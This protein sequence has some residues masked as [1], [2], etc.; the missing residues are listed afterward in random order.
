MLGTF[1]FELWFKSYCLF[2]EWSLE[3][4][5]IAK[6]PLSSTSTPL[7]C[8]SPPSTDSAAAHRQRRRRRR[9]EASRPLIRLALAP[10]RRAAPPPP[11][12]ASRWSIPGRA[13]CP[14]A[15]RA[16]QAAATSPSPW[17][18]PGSAR[19]TLLASARALQN[20]Q[21]AIPLSLL[22]PPHSHASERRRR[23]TPNPGELTPPR[24]R[25]HKP[26]PPQ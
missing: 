12:V 9:G 11:P 8:F 20:P 26:A 24:S 17:T 21:N 14:A 19:R 13:T 10:T 5:E 7:L 4:L 16:A 18:A 23:T 25:H 15:S 22:L 6:L 1:P 3:F 2:T